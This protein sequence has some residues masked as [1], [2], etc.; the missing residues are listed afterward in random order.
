[1]PKDILKEIL[2]YIAVTIDHKPANRVTARWSKASTTETMEYIK[3]KLHFNSDQYEEEDVPP[4]V[5]CILGIDMGVLKG[6]EWQE[7]LGELASC[8]KIR[9]VVTV[10]NIKSGVLFTD[11]LLDQYNFVCLQMDTFEDF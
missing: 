1:M 9:F 5:L 7:M 3:R 4:L 10:D 11:Q 8:K 2:N 6:Q